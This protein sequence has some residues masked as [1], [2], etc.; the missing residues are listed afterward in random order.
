M[1]YVIKSIISLVNNKTNYNET[2]YTSIELKSLLNFD[3]IEQI[4]TMLNQQ[5]ITL[6]SLIEIITQQFSIRLILEESKYNTDLIIVK[7]DTILDHISIVH[8]L[9]VY[10]ILFL[11]YKIFVDYFGK[12]LNFKKFICIFIFPFYFIF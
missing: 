2:K 3:D 4:Q 1:I 11:F 12:G 8:I 10:L 5:N 6:E 7:H 9:F